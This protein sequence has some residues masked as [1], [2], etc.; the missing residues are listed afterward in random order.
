VLPPAF[1][2]A[3]LQIDPAP[4]KLGDD[5]VLTT[6]VQNTGDLAGT[7]DGALL[8]GG[9]E[10][11]AQPVK[12]A[13]GQSVDVT[14]DLT[15]DAAGE[16]EL[17]LGDATAAFV[18]VEPVRLANGYVIRRSISGG[19]SSVTIVN[20]TGSDAVAVFSRSSNKRKPVLA[21]YIRAGKKAKVGGIPDGKY[22]FWDSCGSDFN[23]TMRDFYT[24]VEYKRWL[25]PLEFDTTKSTRHWTSYWSDAYYNY[26]QGHSQTT[27]HWTNWTLT[28]GTG[29]SKYT[30]L[31]SEDGFPQF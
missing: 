27:T 15:A 7:F 25:D 2:V 31:V 12:V 8:V 16:Y 1:T 4:A 17:T 9:D 18:I 21:V 23:W 3:P 28:M 29:E 24:P 19:R 14:Y 20:K 5:V 11:M 10:L 6:T 26:S 22:V 13:P 30:K